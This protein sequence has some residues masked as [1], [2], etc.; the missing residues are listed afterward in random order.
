[1]NIKKIGLIA[2]V[3]LSL[4]IP[5]FAI[6][7]YLDNFNTKYMTTGTKLDSCVLCHINADPYSDSAR[8]NYGI[9]FKSNGH[10]FTKIEPLDSDKDKFVNI[11]EIKKRTFPGN[12]LS[13]P[14]YSKIDGWKFN[15]L[16]GNKIKDAGEPGI[17][18]WN[19][20]IKGVDLV[21]RTLVTRT[22]KTDATGY[23]AFTNIVN[24]VYV[25][26]EEF[27]LVW[28]PTT[29]GSYTIRIPATSTNVRKMFG[30]KKV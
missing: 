26:S 3:M 5:A 9:D 11:L 30:N 18:N 10:N 2:I 21:R 29:D 15:D 25:V 1:M 24:G 28:I 22:V 16:N 20:T 4:V 13:H 6:S 19:I 17:A 27:K 8:N 14:N 7:N 12:A 23:F